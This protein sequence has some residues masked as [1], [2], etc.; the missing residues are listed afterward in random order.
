MVQRILTM[1]SMTDCVMKDYMN[2]RMYL[3]SIYVIFK[4]T[5]IPTL[6]HTI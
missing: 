3:R 6:M 2:D 5:L 1:I 4:H